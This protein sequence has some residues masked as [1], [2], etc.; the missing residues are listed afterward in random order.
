M[1]TR[2]AQLALLLGLVLVG[3][4]V[5][6]ATC[7][8]GGACG[9]G[10][11]LFWTAPI[12]TTENTALVNLAGFQ[13]LWATTAGVSTGITT[14]TVSVGPLGVP[15]APAPNTVARVLLSG[16]RFPSGAIFTCV[17]AFDSLGVVSDCSNEITFTFVIGS[18]RATLSSVGTRSGSRQGV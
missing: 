2:A 7:A 13:V 18:H 16:F 4:D 17:K 1:R 6:S 14:T 12:T 5:L 15:S 11:E 10:N 9:P 8:A 3:P